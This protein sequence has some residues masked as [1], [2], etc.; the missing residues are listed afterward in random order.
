MGTLTYLASIVSALHARVHKTAMR[1]PNLS[2]TPHRRELPV[3]AQL[4]YSKEL[5][6]GNQPLETQRWIWPQFLGNWL[7]GPSFPRN[8]RAFGNSALDSVPVSWKPAGRLRR[9][10]FQHSAPYCALQPRGASSDAEE[11]EV[12]SRRRQSI[13]SGKDV[14]ANPVAPPVSRYAPSQSS[15]FSSLDQSAP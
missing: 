7:A 14:H 1:I 8:T 15:M 11:F 5:S 4:G 6:L 12:A 10:G 13:P 9:C 2:Q 3:R